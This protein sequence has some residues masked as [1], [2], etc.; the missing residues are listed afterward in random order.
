MRFERA[1]GCYLAAMVV[2]PTLTLVLLAPPRWPYA[3]LLGVA[4]LAL[5]LAL[6]RR[7]LY[8]LRTVGTLIESLRQGDFTH[9]AAAATRGDALGE[10]L[11]ELNALSDSLHADRLRVQESAALLRRVLAVIDIAIFAFGESGRL[12]LI[13]P[14]AQRLLRLDATAALGQ[15]A[16]ALGLDLVLRSA[17]EQT[18]ALDFPGGSGRYVVRHATFRESGLPHRLLVLSDFSR[19]LSESERA[20]FSRLVRVMTHEINNSLTPV[21]SLAQ[22]LHVMLGGAP[23]TSDQLSGAREGLAVIAQRAAALNR[24]MSAFGQLARLPPPQRVRTELTALL[25]QL[26]VLEP[27]LPIQFDIGAEAHAMVDP[28]QL[29]Q[30][31]INL[32]KNATDASLPS[33][34]GVTIRLLVDASNVEIQIIDDGPGPPSADNLFV[35]FFTTK[36]NGSGIG[37]VLSKQIIEAHAGSLRLESRGGAPGCVARVIIPNVEIN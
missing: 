21:Q 30:A 10:V 18:L 25:A 23:L 8:P 1:L 15:P 36:P 5:A 24:F 33:H 28:D 2:L 34:G 26:A 32:L 17:N 31:L 11:L 6:R 9:R 27:L 7:L 37:L 14:S 3:L 29:T 20:A 19:P 4:L 22:T 35:P 13:N 16:V 12:C